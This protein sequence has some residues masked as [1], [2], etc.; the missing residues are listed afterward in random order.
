ML[1]PP[2]P[3][4]TTRHAFPTKNVI[5]IRSEHAQHHRPVHQ[6]LGSLECRT[7]NGHMGARMRHGP[8]PQVAEHPRAKH[9]RVP[10]LFCEHR[11]AI[12]WLQGSPHLKVLTARV[13]LKIC[14]R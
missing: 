12:V 6:R 11:G 4:D 7:R 10:R 5:S 9:R 14:L 2:N 3:A 1:S 8:S 13:K